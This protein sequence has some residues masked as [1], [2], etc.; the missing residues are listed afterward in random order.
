MRRKRFQNKVATSSFT[1][2]V[3]TLITLG[4]WALGGA[5][6]PFIWLGLIPTGIT[7]YLLLEL[8][9]RNALIRIRSRLTTALYLVLTACNPILHPYKDI[10]WVVV[11]VTI[12]YY[13]LFMSYQKTKASGYIFHA[14]TF[15][16]IGCLFFP[17]LIFFVPFY[18]LAMIIQLRSFTLRSLLASILGMILPFWLKIGWEFYQDGP[19]NISMNLKEFCYVSHPNLSFLNEHQWVTFGLIALFSLIAILHYTRT[20]FN[21]K[22]RTRMLLYV[23]IIQEFVITAFLLLQP[24]HYDVL[25]HLLIMNSSP[26]IAHYFTLT[27]SRTTN[28]IFIIFISLL[29]FI[30][31]YNTW[32]PSFIF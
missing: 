25:I 15:I 5:G 29:I 16:G 4:L 24:Q 17:Q 20:N 12:A 7:A 19:R 10:E 18:Y 14:F 3:A 2:P 6:D 1:L 27:N 28:I 8:N 30:T 22:I 9:N 23:I 11:C 32:I 31:I 26:L 21:D 13:L